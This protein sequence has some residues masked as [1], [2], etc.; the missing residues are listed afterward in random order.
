[1]TQLLPQ[2]VHPP[3]ASALLEIQLSNAAKHFMLGE[4]WPAYHIYGY[5]SRYIT[6]GSSLGPPPMYTYACIG[7]IN[8]KVYYISCGVRFGL[9]TIYMDTP[10]GTLI[11]FQTKCNG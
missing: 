10:P 3:L 2:W 1:M 8:L 4:V 9:P 5:T 11:R 6:Y 7:K